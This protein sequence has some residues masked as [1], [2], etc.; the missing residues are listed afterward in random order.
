M[1]S[2]GKLPGDLAGSY[3]EQI[4]R[5]GGPR[6]TRRRNGNGNTSGAAARR[7]GRPP[8]SA[9]GTRTASTGR[10]ERSDLRSRINDPNATTALGLNV[11]RVSDTIPRLKLR[12][13]SPLAT[14]RQMHRYMGNAMSAHRH[15]L[16]NPRRVTGAGIVAAQDVCANAGGAVTADVEKQQRGEGGRRFSTVCPLSVVPGP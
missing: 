10:T 4:E 8:C 11:R 5:G 12:S 15:S 7:P 13:S 1:Q 9:H 14:Y 6:K 16:N 3:A 2:V